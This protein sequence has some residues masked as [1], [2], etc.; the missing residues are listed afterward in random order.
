MMPRVMSVSIEVGAIGGVEN[1]GRM[2][3][4]LHRACG[5]IA[6]A[7]GMNARHPL[8]DFG[9]QPFAALNGVSPV[10]AISAPSAAEQVNVLFAISPLI[11][12]LVSAVWSW[13]SRQTGRH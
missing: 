6:A 4:L 3:C 12:Q 7:A 8:H 2:H 9:G 1:G 11:P 13:C 5:E 10:K